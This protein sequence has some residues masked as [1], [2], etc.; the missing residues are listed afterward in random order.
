[1]FSQ[2]LV[3]MFALYKFFRKNVRKKRR[4]FSMDPICPGDLNSPM[5][6]R[7]PFRGPRES[8]AVPRGFWGVFGIPWGHWVGLID[9]LMIHEAYMPIAKK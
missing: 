7:R 9:L 6:L 1:M 5:R 4:K 3:Q 8:R 2:F